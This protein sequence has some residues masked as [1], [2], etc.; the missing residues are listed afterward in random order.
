MSKREITSTRPTSGGFRVWGPFLLLGAIP[1]VVILSLFYQSRQTSKLTRQ[2]VESRARSVAFGFT[3]GT[4]DRVGDIIDTQLQSELRSRITDALA[5]QG[6]LGIDVLAPEQGGTLAVLM[7]GGN[8]R[9]SRVAGANRLALNAYTGGTVEI[10][11][12]ADDRWYGAVPLR[13]TGGTPRGVVSFVLSTAD[14]AAVTSQT[15][16]GLSALLI[17]AIVLSMLLMARHFVILSDNRALYAAADARSQERANLLGRAIVAQE[18][19]RRLLAGE[20]HDRP[21]QTLSAL[22]TRLQV[23]ELH[24]ERGNVD[25]V[26]EL[27]KSF[28]G[29]IMQEVGGLRQMMMELRPP[30]LEER[31]LGPALEGIMRD[32]LEPHGVA[33]KLDFSTEHQLPQHVEI[34][35]YRLVDEA[36]RNTVKYAQATLVEVRI[37]ERDRVVRARYK[38]NG[39]GFDLSVLPHRIEE[40]HYGLPSM[41]ERVELGGGRFQ[42]RSSPGQGVVIDSL[43]PIGEDDEEGT[44]A[45]SDGK[46]V[47]TRLQAESR[48]AVG[49]TTA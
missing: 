4:G 46:T 6:V 2:T 30:V 31:G 20:I 14:A 38:D 1:I 34:V 28:R 36:M 24:A 47:W 19:E 11:K 22:V 17:A 23:A 12:V 26:K 9:P 37:A 8:E 29:E 41:R 7:S 44:E 35:L 13:D 45:T 42:I 15:R 49:E 43:V 16:T 40:G 32:G 33:W 10:N 25:K 27:I 48:V 18:R 3:L 21:V 39:K 5:D